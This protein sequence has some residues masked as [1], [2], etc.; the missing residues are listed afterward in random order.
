[1]DLAAYR[2]SAAEQLRAQDLLR[3]LPVGRRSILEIGARDGFHTRL[4]AQR[5]AHVV[6]LDLEQ[7]PIDIPGVVAVRGD[8][9]C[10]DFPDASFDCVLCSEVLEHV[11]RLDKAASEIT[12]VTRYEALIGVPYRQDPRVGQLTCSAC[13]R[14]NPAYGHLHSFDEQKLQRL[15]A[16]LRVQTVSFVGL[17]SER[18]NA[19]AAWLSD[20]AR[21]PWG[22]YEQ[23]EP[24]IYC[25]AHMRPPASRSLLEKTCSRLAHY[26]NLLQQP[27]VKPTPAWI[28]VL[29]SKAS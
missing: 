2:A 22:V 12:R 16:P 9:T 24:C 7:P 29:F 10:L 8:V 1:M 17:R 27:F 18:T 5:F 26:V 21:N 4:L 25:G 14:T 6:A 28:H 19:L 15:F 20:R 23:D 13:G 11:R 3:L